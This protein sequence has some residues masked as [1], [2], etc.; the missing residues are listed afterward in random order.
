MSSDHP[1]NVVQVVCRGKAPFQS[2]D[3]TVRVTTVTTG[4]ESN[5]EKMGTTQRTI[6]NDVNGFRAEMNR[7]G[8][9]IQVHGSKL[10]ENPHRDK[11][12]L[13]LV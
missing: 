9:K 6:H 7:P 10:Q 3:G 12:P 4:G 5:N 2:P 1:L 8:S 11:I 13:D